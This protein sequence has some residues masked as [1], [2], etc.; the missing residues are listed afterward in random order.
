MSLRVVVIGDAHVHYGLNTARLPRPYQTVDGTRAA[1]FAD[2][3]G[4]LQAV[5]AA[6]LGADVSFIGA[7]GDDPQAQLIADFLDAHHI[8]AHL[9]HDQHT[10]TG[11]LWLL[12]DDEG[13]TARV[14]VPGAN[15]TLPP[16]AMPADVIADAQML[17]TTLAP[18]LPTLAR[19][20]DIAHDNG[21]T[22]F[23]KPTPF[24]RDAESLIN[25]AR[26]LTPNKSQLETL[27]VHLRPNDHPEHQV[28]VCTLGAGGAQWFRR[29][30]GQVQSD[31]VPG[32]NVRPIDE[33]GAGDVF[34]VALAIA[35]GDNLP[36]PEAIRRANAAG[37]VTITRP[38]TIRSAPDRA[39]IHRLLSGEKP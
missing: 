39:A 21:V 4:L 1:Q 6:N 2:G 35:L 31:R 22:T 5:T 34:A 8:T 36:L 37:A 27:A 7:V 23:L 28:M 29:V 19:A 10:S 15:A 25:Q 24:D 14:R 3:R 20:F 18:P 17:I 11:M 30:G 32:F 26:Y 33:T 38:G 9:H 16:S 12:S 13:R